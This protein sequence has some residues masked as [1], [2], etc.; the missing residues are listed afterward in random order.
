[1]GLSRALAINFVFGEDHHVLRAED[2]NRG[3]CGRLMKVLLSQSR[4]GRGMGW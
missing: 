1:M 3:K 4:Q 2:G